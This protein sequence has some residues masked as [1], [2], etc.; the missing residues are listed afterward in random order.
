MGIG[1]QIRTA[2]KAAKLTQEQLANKLGVM[3]SVISKYEN[4]MIEPSITQLGKIAEALD[5]SIEYLLG[6]EKI[7]TKE[8]MLQ[9]KEAFKNNNTRLVEK[10][11][12][13][14]E[15]TIGKTDEKIVSGLKKAA[16]IV[17]SNKVETPDL[18]DVVQQHIQQIFPNGSEKR[19]TGLP[20]NM[21]ECILTSEE[22]DTIVKYI[23]LDEHGKIT[24]STILDVE[25]NR[26]YNSYSQSNDKK[27]KQ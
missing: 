13:F 21:W 3:H 9:V 14:P 17:K 2:R 8:K 4:D 16:E 24:V 19:F 20:N 5:V 27:T 22:F 1:E 25:Y 26:I 10:L 23:A 6:Y 15:G 18:V 11:M 12:G 7:D